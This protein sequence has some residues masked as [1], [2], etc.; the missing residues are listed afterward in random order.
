M[1]ENKKW[2][3]EKIFNL[4]KEASDFKN[5]M[6]SED[7][8]SNLEVKIKRCGDHGSK[9]KVKSWNPPVQNKVAKKNKKGKKDEK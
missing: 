9:F 7:V 4:Y 6:L 3:T 2:K 5:K 1:S 8:S